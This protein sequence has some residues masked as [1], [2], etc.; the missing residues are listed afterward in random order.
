[1]DMINRSGTDFKSWLKPSRSANFLPGDVF[2][3]LKPVQMETDSS[4]LWT[5]DL[6]CPTQTLPSF[7]AANESL[8]WDPW[9]QK[10]SKI[11]MET[12]CW[13]GT[14]YDKHLFSRVKFMS[15]FTD[16]LFCV[17]SNQLQSQQESPVGFWVHRQNRM[18]CKNECALPSVV[19]FFR[20]TTRH[21]QPPHLFSFQEKNHWL[22]TKKTEV[23]W[24]KFYKWIPSEKFAPKIPKPFGTPP[25]P[26]YD[27]DVYRRSCCC[28]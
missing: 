15:S 10:W 3:W 9:A 24:L 25:L 21:F 22:K 13:E 20:Q 27:S 5:Y 16:V 23:G 7:L 6:G 11:L 8:G 19:P 26:R 2:L 28:C 12:I 14:T 18:R 4:L 17:L 1:M